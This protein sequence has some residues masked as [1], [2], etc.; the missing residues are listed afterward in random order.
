M[1]TPAPSPSCADISLAQM[2]ARREARYASQQALLARFGQALVQLTLVNPGPIKDTAQARL[3]FDEGLQALE[4]ALKSAGQAV[5]AQ[6][7]A[8]LVTGPELLMAVAADAWAIKRSLVA[9]EEQH[10]LGRLWDVDVLD[11]TGT[12]VSRQQLGRPARRCLL[13]DKSAHACARSGQHALA[14]LQRAIQE[15][16]DAFRSSLGH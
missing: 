4:Q 3:V 1:L 16:V 12:S 14:D 5:V 7:G 9:L 13:C 2:L 10:P 8:Y 6:E 11:L 15:K